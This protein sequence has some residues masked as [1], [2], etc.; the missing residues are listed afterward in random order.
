[1]AV[2][3]E[4]SN[5]EVVGSPL[6][7][8]SDKFN[9]PVKVSD[10][11][12]IQSPNTRPTVDS[13]ANQSPT[14]GR[15]YA[16]LSIIFNMND[17]P[18]KFFTNILVKGGGANLPNTI[19]LVNKEG[20]VYQKS[21]LYDGDKMIRYSSLTPK[22]IGLGSP[23]GIHNHQSGI[24]DHVTSKHFMGK[25]MD[26]R[27]LIGIWELN[28]ELEIT[29]DEGKKMTVR[30]YE[31]LMKSKG[32]N[33]LNMTLE[34]W[35]MDTRYRMADIPILLTRIYRPNATVQNTV[36]PEAFRDP[37]VKVV[38]QHNKETLIGSSKREGLTDEEID[39]K[40]DEAQ[41]A[42]IE[43]MKD[44]FVKTIYKGDDEFKEF[45]KLFNERGMEQTVYEE[46]YL[47]ISKKFGNEL[48]FLV[49]ED[50]TIRLHN[51]QN[52]TKLGSIIDLD[53]VIFRDKTAEGEVQ[54]YELDINGKKQYL[55]S[56]KLE[57]YN[58]N[59]RT[60]ENLASNLIFSTSRFINKELQ[61]LLT[62]G[63]MDLDQRD[64]S[65]LVSRIQKAYASALISSAKKMMNEQQYSEFK[66]KLVEISN[67]FIAGYKSALVLSNSSSFRN[68]PEIN[69]IEITFHSTVQNK[70]LAQTFIDLLS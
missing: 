34:A 55:S 63:I 59:D 62:L 4:V 26:G 45:F 21:L 31:E 5:D 1:M 6:I 41:E 27:A 46:Y 66:E 40:L 25:G 8:N 56:D 36:L 10:F 65:L 7:D 22:E 49:S 12:A 29:V 61:A 11:L 52:L 16:I 33:D 39:I 47:L 13:I 28:K 64:A 44:T 15:A 19:T 42:A 68:S 2:K 23:L 54:F 67:E 32:I 18:N 38:H 35:A 58:L 20:I 69:G 53:V 50:A 57:Q 48:A 30:E 14:E 70:N 17:H 37:N 60:F 51:P 9:L 24:R 43:I 3:V